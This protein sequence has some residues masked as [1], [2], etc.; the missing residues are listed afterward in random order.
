MLP[1][2]SS[3]SGP[4]ARSDSAVSPFA[5]SS[6]SLLDVSK[7]TEEKDFSSFR[8]IYSSMLLAQ[9]LALLL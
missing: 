8:R 7:N 2:Y 6:D 3:S 9:W 4:A 5:R 1:P